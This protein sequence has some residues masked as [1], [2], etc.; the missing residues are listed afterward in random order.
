M[1][2]T[3]THVSSF[4]IVVFSVRSRAIISRHTVILPFFFFF[5][6]IGRVLRVF[7]HLEKI[8]SAI[9]ITVGLLAMLE[10]FSYS[11]Y[12]YVVPGNVYIHIYLFFVKGNIYNKWI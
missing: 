7:L 9:R 2:E 12:V 5:F 3:F 8:F 4:R 1:L 11:F 6:V 10:T